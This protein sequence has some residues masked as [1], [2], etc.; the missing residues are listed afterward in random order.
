MTARTLVS[1]TI[2]GA[3]ALTVHATDT[4]GH[5]RSAAPK[6]AP[7][8]AA[9]PRTLTMEELHRL[10]GVP[11]GWK[12]ALPEGDAARGRQVFADLE[13]FKCHAIKGETF[14]AVEPDARNAGPELTGMGTHHP[15]E[16][17]AESILLP[18]AVVV[19]GPGHTGPDGRSIMP[20]YAD[21][22]SVKQLVD[23][24]AFIRS[25]TGGDSHA[26]HHQDAARET[27]AG[28]YRVRLVFARHG[29]GHADHGAHGHAHGAAGARPDTSPAGAGSGAPSDA[30]AHAGHGGHGSTAAGS[31]SGQA[32][33]GAS[34][35]PRAAGHAHGPADGAVPPSSPHGQGHLMAFI[36]DRDIGDA[37]PYLRVTATMHAPGTAPRTVMLAPMVSD[38]GFHY[39]ADVVLP[40]RTQKI[41]L[42]VGPASMAV[43]GSLSGRYKTLVTAAF[44]WQAAAK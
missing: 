11:R 23:L 19:S 29:A 32:S 18:D 34:A 7:A 27:V 1:L 15:A 16:Y 37:V 36:A 42:S 39:G 30:G 35:T 25:Q 13:C 22:I 10:G 31:G 26:G 44:D 24:V 5:D 28:E 41:T 38:R 3:L 17:F 40:A 43:M 6:A 2:A 21:A 9:G 14:P 12:F 20:S 8:P 4:A 33:H